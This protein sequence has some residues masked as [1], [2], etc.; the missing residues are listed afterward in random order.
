MGAKSSLI[1]HGKSLGNIY[2]ELRNGFRP[3]EDPSKMVSFFSFIQDFMS[4][5]KWVIDDYVRRL[6]HDHGVIVIRAI[7]EGLAS[8]SKAYSKLADWLQ[9]GELSSSSHQR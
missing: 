7:E 5:Q 6:G 9:K 3:S 8:A 1:L 4:C 2:P